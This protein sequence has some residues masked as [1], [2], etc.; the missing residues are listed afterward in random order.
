MDSQSGSETTKDNMIMRVSGDTTY[1]N[2]QFADQ[3]QD[4]SDTVESNIDPTRK[5][6]DTD[7]ATL[8][9]F[10]SRPI[11]IAEYEW[12]TGTTL[13]EDFNPWELYC[14]NP[15]VA[16]RIANYKLMRAQLK[17][18]IVINGNGFQYGRAIASYLPLAPFDS[19]TRN[20]A[21]IPEDIVGASQLPH[22]YLDPT[23]STGGEMV[24]PFFYFQNYLS[25]PDENWST[26]GTMNIRSINALKHA[27]GATDRVTISV[28]AWLE[29]VSLNVLTSVEQSTLTPQSG[30]EVDMANREGIVSGPATTVAK[31]AGALKG[32]PTIGP[33]ARAT[34]V[35]ANLVSDVARSMGYCRPTVTKDPV[36]FKPIA[37]SQLATTTTP[38]GAIKMSVDDKQEL[39]IDPAISGIGT[40]DPMNIKDI[41]KRESYLTTFN[42]AIGTAPESLLWNS[43]VTPVTWAEDGLVPNGIHFPACAMAALPFKYWTGSMRFRFQIV[44]SAFHKGRLKVVYDPEF[45]AS[46]EYNTNYLEIVDLADKTDFTIEIGNGQE[47][48][49]LPHALPGFDSVTEIYSTT[50]YAVGAPGNGVIGVYIVN[51]LT[52]PNSV[53]NNDIQINVFVSMGDDFEV[54]VPDNHFQR[55]VFKPQSGGGGGG[56]GRLQSQSG[57]EPSIGKQIRDLSSQIQEM[58]VNR[59]RQT[60]QRA[61]L[62]QELKNLVKGIRQFPP[63]SGS[64]I[65]PESENTAEPSAPQQEQADSVGPGKT[66]HEMINLVYTGESI[67]SFRPLLKRYNLHEN[68]GYA[69]F[70]SYR[71]R[72]GRRCMF[73]YLRGNVDGA[74]HVTAASDPYNYCNT[75]LMHWVTYAFSGWRGSIRNK[76]LPSGLI[77]GAENLAYYIQR[78]PIGTLEFS[79]GAA[80]VGSIS[81]ESDTAYTG[82]VNDSFVSFPGDTQQLS[83]VNGAVFQHG[84]INPVAE[85]ESPYYS[86]FRFSPGKDENKTGFAT[87]EESFDYRIFGEAPSTMAIS[88][89]VAAGEDFQ[90]YFFT[91]LPVMYY[92]EVPPPV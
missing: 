11:K 19:L 67:T 38:D 1:Q 68:L 90:V 26:L 15:R 56:G 18:K 55:F 66:N 2:V 25:I 73:P 82:V 52:T 31:M 37:Q 75:V 91:G 81:S 80:G 63:Q 78:A 34:E 79:E 5:L 83:G 54:F 9:N 72:F 62:I 13:F 3:M 39:T 47:T 22:I 20:S 85:F 40:S 57:R 12:G 49:L 64:E 60:A 35:G 10:F 29:D 77:A 86:P 6:M 53:V 88:K 28:F 70:A 89:F 32:V 4:Y 84:S 16:N 65:V 8:D 7:D 76:F 74:V 51:E 14:E 48:T 43:R 61:K 44:C 21:L 33:F 87:F 71:V 41:A 46:N 45:L 17:V 36:P 23:N 58:Q 42:W 59:P 30:S 24:L 50:P 27:N 69:G 92:E